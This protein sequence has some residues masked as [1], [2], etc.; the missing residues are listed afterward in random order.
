MNN[1]YTLRVFH[2]DGHYNLDREY[3]HLRS[4][5]NQS[6]R[7]DDFEVISNHHPIAEVIYYNRIYKMQNDRK[8]VVPLRIE[9]WKYGQYTII[10][11]NPWIFRIANW[12]LTHLPKSIR[13]YRKNWNYVRFF[14][15]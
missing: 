13:Q 8:P 2:K 6:T 4:D 7:Y 9:K 11:F 12:I 15:M 14:G 10:K 1:R 3:N 5:Y